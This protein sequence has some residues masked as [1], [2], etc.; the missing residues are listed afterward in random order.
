M[1][2]PVHRRPQAGEK[3]GVHG[4]TDLVARLM[5]GPI[6]WLASTTPP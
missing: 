2:P 5:H 3:L 4:Q 1:R 6:G